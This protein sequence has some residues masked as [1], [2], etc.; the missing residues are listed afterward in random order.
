M[1]STNDKTTRWVE[2]ENGLLI[3]VLLRNDR[4]NDVFLQISSNFIISQS[5]RVGWR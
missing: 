5:H 4:L 1:R 2:M 3:K